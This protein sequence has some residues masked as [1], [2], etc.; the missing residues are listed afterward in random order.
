MDSEFTWKSSPCL[1][2]SPLLKDIYWPGRGGGR[3]GGGA[4]PLGSLCGERCMGP[5]GKTDDGWM[6]GSAGGQGVG[7]STYEG[8]VVESEGDVETGEGVGGRGGRLGQEND[9]DEHLPRGVGDRV[10]CGGGDGW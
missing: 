2:P 6:A 10:D 8:R 3:A 5:M 9:G 4:R 1:S 7:G